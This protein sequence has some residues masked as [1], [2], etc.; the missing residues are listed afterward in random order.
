MKFGSLMFRELKLSK[1]SIFLQFGLLIAW[2][3]LSWGLL[4]SSGSN[5][6][7]NEELTVITDA[8]IIMTALIGS[9]SL[10]L[11][12]N[13]KSDINSGWLMYSY[14]LPISPFERTLSRFVRRIS[15]CL[16]SILL[17]LCN[18]AAVCAY[19]AKPFGANQ[20]VW[21]TAVL[22]AVILGSLPNDFFVLRARSRADIKKLTTFSGMTTTAF[23][24]V[25]VIVIFMASGT[26]LKELADG[27]AS[28]V[29]PV[30]TASALIWAIPL[31]L[32]TLAASFFTSYY[33]LK[34]AY[35]GA[36]KSESKITEV[37]PK[38]AFAAKTDGASGLLYKEL[39][40]NKLMLI[41]AAAVPFLMTAFPFCFS[42]IDAMTGSV[43]AD[44]VFETATN[45]MIR[46]MMFVIGFFIV[47]G[48]MSEVFRGDNKKSWAYFIASS[49]Q[50]V[51]G[52]LYHKYT[53]T[54]MINLICMVS[55]FFA[56]NLLATVHYFAA[57][58]ELTTSMQPLYLSGVF[59]MMGVSALDIPFTVRYGSKKGS[60][61]KMIIML[62]LCTA[63][64]AVFALLPDNVRS[65]LIETVIAIVKGESVNDILMLILSL[66]P[67]VMS[68]AF[69]YSYKI[70]CRLFMKGVSE[71]DK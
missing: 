24:A 3:A 27:N 30:F 37:S 31:L 39:K 62:S 38:A 51:K 9:M 13:F 59:M 26:D 66:L 53:V 45:L 10:L 7:N 55:G 29:L 50:G 52:F 36:V 48:L 12:D 19:T 32:L 63:A 6:I 17:S 43:G 28:I 67:F 64:T 54:L 70:S 5:G 33:S 16:A 69:L 34:S 49:P 60:M 65:G 41:L 47:C 23:L 56:D 25:F 46:M 8:I 58:S 61:I 35:H 11:D 18:T 1:K 57:G 14:A 68:A 44:K 15:L 40:Q 22:A 21:H 20:I 4:L 2:I 42:A 71:Y